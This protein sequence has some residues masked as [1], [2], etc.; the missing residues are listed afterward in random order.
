MWEIIESF[1][2]W[3]AW[4]LSFFVSGLM[5]ICVSGTP[6]SEVRSL[7]Q[8][9]HGCVAWG[10]PIFVPWMIHYGNKYLENRR[11]AKQSNKEPLDANFTALTP[12]FPKVILV[13]VVYL[14]PFGNSEGLHSKILHEFQWETATSGTHPKLT[15][16]VKEL[17]IDDGI[18]YT[19]TDFRPLVHWYNYINDDNVLVIYAYPSNSKAETTT[20]KLHSL[21]EK[22]K[23]VTWSSLSDRQR[24]EITALFG[25]SLTAKISAVKGGNYPLLEAIGYEAFYQL[26]KEKNISDAQTDE[27]IVRLFPSIFPRAIQD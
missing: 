16:L 27:M 3:Y 1:I 19:V 18:E 25:H 24:F 7:S 8:F 6:V 2:W 13:R 26:Q 15:T 10:V 4:Q 12:K 17:Y 9:L 22:Y 5:N 20:Q 14:Y 11:T 21:A 23:L